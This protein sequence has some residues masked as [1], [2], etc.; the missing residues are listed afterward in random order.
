MSTLRARHQVPDFPWLRPEEGAAEVGTGGRA[1]RNHQA[2]WSQRGRHRTALGGAAGQPSVK[3]Q[4]FE[5]H[6]EKDQSQV[7]ASERVTLYG[8]PIVPRRKVHY[9][10]INPAEA[11]EIFIREGLVRFNYNTK[12]RYYEHNF[13]L[14]LEIE[15][16]EHKARRQDFLVDDE[17]LFRFFLMPAS[18]PM[19]SMAPALKP[20]AK[21]RKKKLIPSC[22]SSTAMI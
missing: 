10:A 16:L 19:W 14:L 12:A 9:G 13:E 21:R 2:V 15:E 8:L 18:R 22:C 7:T 11:R 3:R 1:G 5:P 20:G 4:Y 17:V 6:W